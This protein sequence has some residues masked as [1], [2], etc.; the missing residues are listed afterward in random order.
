MVKH[1]F[2]KITKTVKVIIKV[3]ASSEENL[4]HARFVSCLPCIFS[5]AHTK[6]D[7]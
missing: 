6:N 4:V 7:E 3:S 2:H 5:L 1:A